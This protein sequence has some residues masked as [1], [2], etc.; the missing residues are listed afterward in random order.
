M[1]FLKPGRATIIV[2][3]ILG[4][5]LTS[6]YSAGAHEGPPYPIIVDKDIGP[7]LVSVWGDPDVGTGTF[8][9]IVDPHQKGAPLPEKTSVRIAVQPVT[10]RLDE[11]LYDA[12]RENVRGRL[13]YKAEAQFDSQERWRLRVLV[14]TSG[15]DGEVTSEVDVTPPGYG[16]WELLLYA[17]PFIAVGFLW[18]R[19]AL[20]GRSLK[21]SLLSKQA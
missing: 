10:G 3:I 13:Q 8:F 7:C 9:I 6:P 17:L 14:Q 21:N 5:T 18:L 15:G 12:L 1:S 11:V 2:C 4:V 19:A 20:L 16:G